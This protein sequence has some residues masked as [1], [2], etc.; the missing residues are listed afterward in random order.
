MKNVIATAGVMAACLV[1]AP[2]A[3]SSER[4]ALTSP[5]PGSTLTGVDGNV[6]VDGRIGRLEILVWRWATAPG[7]HDYLR[8]GYWGRAAARP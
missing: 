3:E 2:R 7:G 5:A 6:S 8:P 4:A 1:C